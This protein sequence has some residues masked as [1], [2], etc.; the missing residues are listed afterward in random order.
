[1][2]KIAKHAGCPRTLHGMLRVS[3]KFDHGQETSLSHLGQSDVTAKFG[4]DVVPTLL[5]HSLS[6]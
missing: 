5:K 3:A 1:M 6:L 2:K 4:G